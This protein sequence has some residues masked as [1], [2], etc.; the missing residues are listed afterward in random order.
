[1]TDRAK[2][3]HRLRL[4]GQTKHPTAI[5]AKGVFSG[6]ASV[7]DCVDG[8]GDMV[9]PG[10]FAHSLSKRKPKDIRMLFQHDPAKPVGVWLDVF[11]DQYGL[12][13]RGKLTK[14]VQQASELNQ[15]LN[16]GAIDGLSIGFK[17]QRARRNKTTGIRKIYQLDLWEIS[18]VT[19]PMLTSARILK[20]K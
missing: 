16:Q 10:A 9:M 4:L 17:T 6:Y 1:M 12:F 20:A 8:G 2:A 14:G 11:E 19:F 15:L 13:V 3:G 5:D 18:L 7:F